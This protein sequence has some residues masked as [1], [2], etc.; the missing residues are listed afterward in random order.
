M[1]VLD[2]NPAFKAHLKRPSMEKKK[3]LKWK[4]GKPNF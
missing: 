2:R 4:T 3:R 1:L